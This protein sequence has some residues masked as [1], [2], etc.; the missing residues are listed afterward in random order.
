[1]NSK[2]TLV[3]TLCMAVILGLYLGFVY[4]PKQKRIGE[5]S[6]KIEELNREKKG[7]EGA[8]ERLERIKENFLSDSLEWEKDRSS[9][10]TLEEADK[11]EEEIK[12]L[13]GV[14]KSFLPMERENFYKK[15][16]YRLEV[17]GYYSHLLNFLF[18]ECNLLSK[19]YPEKL[20][21]TNGIKVSFKRGRWGTLHLTQTAYIL[22]P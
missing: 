7:L 3:I 16:E 12:R 13:R 1:M 18:K 21:L 11:L 19:I 6:S 20:I 8:E 9:F 2:F 15:M 10:L 4:S 5:L 17:K 22:S 14:R